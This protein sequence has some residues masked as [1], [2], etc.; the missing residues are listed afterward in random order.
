M[1]GASRSSQL[2]WTQGTVVE[3][4]GLKHRFLIAI[5]GSEL[6]IEQVRPHMPLSVTS[7]PCYQDA[8]F[9]IPT[10]APMPQS[11]MPQLGDAV[12]ALYQESGVEGDEDHV[13]IYGPGKVTAHLADH[14]SSMVQFWNGS[15]RAVAQEHAH[16]I[17]EEHYQLAARLLA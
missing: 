12:V 9:V 4:D 5:D 16:I 10:A 7:S 1:V 8:L 15:T 17:S 3:V 6:Q 14:G 11:Y 13:C 2:T